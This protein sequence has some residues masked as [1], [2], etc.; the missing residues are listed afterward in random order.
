M[1]LHI[2]DIVQNSITAGAKNIIV[3]IEE[4]LEANTYIIRVE[5]DGCGMSKE[6]LKRVMDPYY[7]SRTTRRVGLGIPLFKQNAERSG[8][9][10]RIR[11]EP[12]KGTVLEAMFVHD[13]IDRP[14][15]GDVAGV[16]VL[17]LGANPDI[18]FRF[19]HKKDLQEYIIDSM[20]IGEALEGFPVSDPGIMKTIKKMIRENLAEIGVEW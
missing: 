18:H 16:M 15:L 12:G 5:D 14:V 20:E 11:S 6:V 3:G 13:N 7:T 9:Y 2:L 4:D 19:G 1:S 10:L 17:L 8:G